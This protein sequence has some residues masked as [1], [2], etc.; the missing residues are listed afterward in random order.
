MI[1]LNT[2]DLSNLF[3]T[4]RNVNNVGIE[5]FTEFPTDKLDTSEGLYVAR[6]YTEHRVNK[7]LTLQNVG[8][9]YEIT[10]RLEMY[11]IQGQLNPVTD[12]VLNLIDDYVDDVLFVNAGYF[13][14]VYTVDQI[15]RKNNECYR[16]VLNL[17]RLKIL[18]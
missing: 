18:N 4:Y 17:T 2:T 12:S 10:D 16:I 8:A 6:F 11:L 15:Y 3:I 9:Q 13:K 14:R 5:V 7:S 1:P